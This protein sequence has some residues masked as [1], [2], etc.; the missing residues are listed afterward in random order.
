[1][2][3]EVFMTEP[4]VKEVSMPPLLLWLDMAEGIL[5][6]DTGLEPEETLPDLRRMEAGV[7]TEEDISESSRIN[8]P[9]VP[10]PPPPLLMFCV[11]S[12]STMWD[13]NREFN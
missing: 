13:L 9:D 12:C 10:P 3:M 2:D 5:D 8:V 4:L 1:M 11:Q 7:V 6:L